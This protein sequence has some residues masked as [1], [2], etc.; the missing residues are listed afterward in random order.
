MLPFHYALRN[1]W[2]DKTRLCQIVAGTALVV[3]LVMAAAALNGGMRDV[4]SASGSRD[5]VILLGIGSEDSVQRSEIPEN[6]AGIAATGIPGVANLLGQPAVSPEIHHMTYL[7]VADYAPAQSMIRGITPA[8]LLVHPEVR[9]ITGS[10]PRPGEIMIGRMA[11]RSLR[12]PDSAL[13][14]GTQVHLENTRLVVSGVFAAPGTVMESEIWMPL[15]DLRTLA[16]RS[17]LSCLTLRMTSP[18]GVDDADLFTKQRLD[19]EMTAIRESDYYDRL[20]RFFQ[21]IRVMTWITAMLITVGALFGGLNTLHAAF[22]QRVRESATLQAIGFGRSALLTSFMQESLL[23]CL[24]GTLVGLTSALLLFDGFSV[25]FAIGSFTMH[26]TPA[27]A[28]LGLATGCVLG[29]LGAL[30]AATHCLLPPLPAAL[31]G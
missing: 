23:A 16:G 12:L 29:L 4:L 19:L 30:P 22:A 27:V 28:G 31:R 11:W 17:S 7:T 24:L 8:A 10:F 5:N 6:S 26:V 13:A 3:F 1:L 25:A 2:R 20:N 14:I 21:P 18:E 9:L 15:G